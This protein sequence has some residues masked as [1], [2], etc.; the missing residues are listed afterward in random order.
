MAELANTGDLPTGPEEPFG[1]SIWDPAAVAAWA[2]GL[3]ASTDLDGDGVAET[4]VLGDTTGAGPG[5]DEEALAVA[6]D[7]DL[8][9]H[10][11]RLSVLADDGRY[12]VW[13]FV[14]GLDGEG[15]WTRL[16]AGSLEFDVDHVDGS[17]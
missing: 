8:D 17:K 15:R 10:A 2:D 11:D 16:D 9:G 5:W 4:V 12:G 13:E 14:R 6:T 1:A 3:E 7:T